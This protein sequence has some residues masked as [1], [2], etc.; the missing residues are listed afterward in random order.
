MAPKKKDDVPLDS[1][2]RL[3]QPK[4]T[5]P[6]EESTEKETEESVQSSES[7]TTTTTTTPSSIRTTSSTNSNS[8]DSS[9]N[10]NGEYRTMV[11]RYLTNPKAEKTLDQKL[12]D[13]NVGFDHRYPLLTQV[14]W[15]AQHSECPIIQDMLKFKN[16]DAVSR[17]T[18]S[19]TDFQEEFLKTLK[20]EHPQDYMFKGGQTELRI[21]NERV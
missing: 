21:N 6:R 15:F 4:A 19:L 12:Q 1:L 20:L 16:Y 7:V 2:Q 17:A 5:T 10:R 13:P 14:T 11:E 3:S 9:N 18:N 8:N